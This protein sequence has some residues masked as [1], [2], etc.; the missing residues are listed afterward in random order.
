[1]HAEQEF[2]NQELHIKTTSCFN[3]KKR[4]MNR[5][6]T[7]SFS[8]EMCELQGEKK[9]QDDFFIR[10]LLN[11]QEKKKKPKSIPLGSP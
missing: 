1:M 7:R 9:S 4:K 10:V 8:T 3:T 11:L 2:L 6:E 5:T